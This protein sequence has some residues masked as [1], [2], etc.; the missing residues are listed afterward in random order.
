[1]AVL[2]EVQV[3][4]LPQPV[5]KGLSA[6]VKHL[7][8][9][10]LTDKHYSKTSVALASRWDKCQS[11]TAAMKLMEQHGVVVGAEEEQRLSGLSE[12]QMIES[13][14]ARMPQQSKEQFQHFFLQLQLIVSTAT[15]I[16]QAL[17]AG[18]ADIVEQ[19]MEDAESTGV[20]QYVLKMAVVQAGSEVNNLKKQHG[21]FVKDAQAKLSRLVKAQEDAVVAKERLVKA[22]GELAVFQSNANEAIKKV[23]MNFAGGSATALLH[24]CVSGWSTYVKKMRVENAIFEEYREDMEAAENRLI[25]AKAEQLKSISKMVNKSAAGGIDQLKSEVFQILADEVREKKD[26]IASAAAVA[27]L[28]AKLKGAA[29]NAAANA[30]KVMARCGAA[31]AQGLRDVCFQEWK[32]YYLDYLKNKAMEEAV[33]EEERRIAEFMQ[34]HSDNAKGLLSGMASATDSGLLHEVLTAWLEYYKEEKQIAAYA[35]AMNGT[36]GKFGA[37]GTR[38]K[39]GAKGV[40]ER[41]HEHNMIMLMLKTFGAWVLDCKIEKIQKVHQMR[42]DGK[43]Q[44]LVGVQ[45]MFRNFAKQLETNINAGG[46]SARDLAAGPRTKAKGL[47]KSDGTVSLPSI[48]ARPGSSGGQ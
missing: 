28:E 18:R 3:E 45:Q 44:Q 5:Q 20:A 41:A 42:V 24:A 17:E 4:P 39:A 1:M 21:A 16:R 31:G 19:A 37:F 32:N 13:L 6:C 23:L 30:K 11:L 48:N 14:V 29:D 34:A 46:D 36:Q 22:Q 2:D 33:K 38:N 40:M 12:A 26:R 7:V 8:E 15:R 9:Q 27:A 10:L 43:R 25:E 35:E 47:Q